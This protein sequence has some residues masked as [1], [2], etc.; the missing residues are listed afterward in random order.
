MSELIALV[1][2]DDEGLAVITSATLQSAGFSVETA[3]DGETALAWLES[4][5][6]TLIVLD[7]NLPGIS[8]PEVLTQ[9]RADDRMKETRIIAVTG[10]P[11]MSE[12][13]GDQVDLVLIKPFGVG[14]L[15]EFALRLAASETE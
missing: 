11:V 12:G 2:E 15:R 10:Y 9:L 13:L 4:S 8:G 6:P 5:V 7:L 14:Q 3:R 1:V